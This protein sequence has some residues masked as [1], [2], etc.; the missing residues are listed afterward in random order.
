MVNILCHHGQVTLFV[1]QTGHGCRLGMG[2]RVGG[3]STLGESYC[4]GKKGSEE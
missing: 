2:R 3:H 4:H 1:M